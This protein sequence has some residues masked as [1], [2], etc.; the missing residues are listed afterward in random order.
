MYVYVPYSSLPQPHFQRRQYKVLQPKIVGRQRN[1]CDGLLISIYIESQPTKHLIHYHT[2]T[3]PSTACDH[4]DGDVAGNAGRDGKESHIFFTT[5]EIQGAFFWNEKNHEMPWELGQL[6]HKKQCR[7]YQSTLYMDRDTLAGKCS[8]L[9]SQVP[10]G[11]WFSSNGF[12]VQHEQLFKLD[13]QWGRQ[14]WGPSG[15]KF[16]VFI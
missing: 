11:Q 14:S 12:K 13:G 16:E 15:F 3:I 6:V 10:C 7:V 5:P 1:S 9:P 4:H 8:I 2:Y